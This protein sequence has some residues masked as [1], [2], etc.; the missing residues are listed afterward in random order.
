MS[1]G[2]AK[3]RPTD[4]EALFLILMRRDRAK[5]VMNEILHRISPSGITMPTPALILDYL[6]NMLMSI[7]MALKLLSN[8]WGTHNVGKMFETITGKPHD[9]PALMEAVKA[10]IMDQKYLLSPAVGIVDHIPELEKLYDFLYLILRSKY[11]KYSVNVE[12]DLPDNFGQY[13]LANVERFYKGETVT[14][15]PGTSFHDNW[16]TESRR[17]RENVE[18]IKVT[19]REFFSNGG[20]VVLANFNTKAL[21]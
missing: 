2:A 14:L 13:L 6:T 9:D 11:A 3:P 7:E 18:S 4:Q 16:E 17:Y 12:Q 1:T 15:T 5:E 8:D 19:L 20:K 21:V 10:A